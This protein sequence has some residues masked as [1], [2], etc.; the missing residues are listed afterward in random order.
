M[1]AERCNYACRITEIK[2]L[3]YL[4]VHEVPQVRAVPLVQQDQADLLPNTF[5][6]FIFSLK[7]AEYIIK[8]GMCGKPKFGSGSVFKN[9]TVTEPSK[10]LTSIQ[11]V[12]R[13]IIKQPALAYSVIRNTTIALLIDSSNERMF[14][15]AFVCLF[16][17]L[18]A[19]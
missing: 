17:S 10:N 13:H 7:N 2:H 3:A 18:L 19:S 4:V 11:T 6:T 12:F 5:Y 15:Q 9:R 16:V 8:L 1:Q 14:Y